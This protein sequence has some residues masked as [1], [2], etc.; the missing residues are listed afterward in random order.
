MNCLNYSGSI[1]RM[2]NENKILLLVDMEGIIGILSMQEMEHNARMA[3]YEISIVI[4]RL[5]REGYH[6][7][8]VCNIHDDGSCLKH[9]IIK[10]MGASFIQ[11]IYNLPS[12]IKQ[13]SHAIMLGFHGK[14]DSGEQFDHTFRADFEYVYYGTQIIGEVGAFYR[15]LSMEG[16]QL[17]MISGEGNFKD[18]VK[19]FPCI[20]HAINTSPCSDRII[21]LEYNSFQQAFEQAIVQL[22]KSVAAIE[23]KF[24]EKVSVEICNPDI[25]VYMMES[26]WYDA[27]RKQFTFLS[28]RDFFSCIY[29]FAMELNKVLKVNCINN[30]NF[31]NKLKNLN[32]EKDKMK[33]LLQ[34]Y[35]EKDIW[36]INNQYRKIMADRVGIAYEDSYTS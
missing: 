36:D 27:E 34:D 22:G 12:V 5:F 33:E 4:S 23:K 30:M 16:I 17:I 18:E 19:E 9:H 25:Y 13:F 21:E 3:Y 31:I 28:L 6:D 7:I 26:P 2:E 32:Y 1:Q 24:T 14:R 11:G 35:T 20:I 10:N 15:W 29:D 8:T